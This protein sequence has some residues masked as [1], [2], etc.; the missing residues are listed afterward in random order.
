VSSSNTEVTCDYDTA[1]TNTN[2]KIEIKHKDSGATGK[3]AVRLKVEP[4]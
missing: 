2:I 4:L 3:V 1:S